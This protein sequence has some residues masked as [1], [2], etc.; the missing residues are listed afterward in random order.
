MVKSTVQQHRG[1]LFWSGFL[2]GTVIKECHG[3]QRRSART[4]FFVLYLT[5]AL[6]RYKRVVGEKIF[7]LPC[8]QAVVL[9]LHYILENYLSNKCQTWDCV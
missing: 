5:N 8:E 2:L 6:E 3:R 7:L 9:M 1:I 4:C